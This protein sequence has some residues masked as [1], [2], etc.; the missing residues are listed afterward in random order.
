MRV[1]VL[2]LD[3]ER[4][5]DRSL[6]AMTVPSETAIMPQCRYQ[7]GLLQTH[8]SLKRPSDLI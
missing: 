7:E 1:S 4:Y 2:A 8:S 5:C 6:T 3:G